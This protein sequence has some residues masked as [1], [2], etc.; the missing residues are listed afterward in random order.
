MINDD[1]MEATEFFT[2]RATPAVAN[3]VLLGIEEVI[4]NV[5]DDDGKKWFLHIHVK[6]LSI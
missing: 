1:E 6:K 3:T 2:F 4:V 5:V